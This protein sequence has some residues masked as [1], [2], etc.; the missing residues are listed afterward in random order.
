MDLTDFC[1][2]CTDSHVSIPSQLTDY[3][4]P[5][6]IIIRSQYSARGQRLRGALHPLPNTSSWHGA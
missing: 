6:G 3:S 4:D 2:T 1:V 5:P